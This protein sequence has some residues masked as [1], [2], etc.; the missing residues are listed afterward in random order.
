MQTMID[1]GTLNDADREAC[2]AKLA[3]FIET[4]SKAEK[5]FWWGLYAAMIKQRTPTQVAKMERE[6]GLAKVRAA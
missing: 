6:R 1:T 3:P 2:I 4:G 5:R